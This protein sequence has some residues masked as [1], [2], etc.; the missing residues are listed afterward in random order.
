MPRKRRKSERQRAKDTAWRWFSKYIRM[1][2]CLKTTGFKD[3][4]K[5]VTCGDYYPFPEL[6]AGHCIGGRNDT[7]L[8]DEK[9]VN[10]QCSKCNSSPQYGGLNG[11][12]AKYHLWYI[13]EYG[14]EDF[15]KKILLSN[16]ADKIPTSELR[17][18][19]DEY[20]LK[21]KKLESS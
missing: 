2:D 11:N 20:R 6:Q 3:Q 7:I 21:F 1:R 4:G 14:R 13:D 18:I 19:S 9:L 16:Q 17:E 5:C 12:Y 10:A 15:E 8:F